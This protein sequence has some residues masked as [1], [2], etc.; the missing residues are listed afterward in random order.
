MAIVV[1]ASIAIKW[2]LAEADSDVA[3]GLIESDLLIAPDLFF[4]ECANVLRTKV[5]RNRLSEEQAVAALLSI[6]A[7]PIRSV[8]GRPHVRAAQRLSFELDQS[9]Y[10]SLYLAIAL[11]ERAVFVTADIPFARAALGHPVYERSVRLIGG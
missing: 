6:E 8:A 2:V 11:A 7:T 1:D 5:R 3:I 4:V 9:A 10:D